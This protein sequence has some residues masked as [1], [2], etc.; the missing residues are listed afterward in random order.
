MPDPTG[1]GFAVGRSEGRGVADADG[2]AATDGL[3]EGEERSAGGEGVG[4]TSGPALGVGEGV[5]DGEGCAGGDGEP[6]DDGRP[7]GEGAGDGELPADGEAGA[8]EAAEPARDGG[9]DS[10]G[11]TREPACAEVATELDTVAG[12]EPELRAPATVAGQTAATTMS[13]SR[14]QTT[15]RRKPFRMPPPTPYGRAPRQGDHR[16][17]SMALSMRP[18]VRDRDGG[19]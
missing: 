15:G 18:R 1:E 11:A 10:D 7:D 19:V 5:V 16:Q 6:D 13:S 3:A 4:T 14:T 17:C 9:D 12:G 2:L 8:G